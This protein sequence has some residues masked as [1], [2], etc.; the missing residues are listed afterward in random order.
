MI[1]DFTCEIHDRDGELNSVKFTYKYADSRTYLQTYYLSVD[2][3]RIFTSPY[4]PTCN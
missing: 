3:D 1:T 4:N 2:H